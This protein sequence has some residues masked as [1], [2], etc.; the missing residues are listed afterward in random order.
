MQIFMKMLLRKTV[1]SVRPPRICLATSSLRASFTWCRDL[2]CSAGRNIVCHTAFPAR[3]PDNGYT[4]SL[5]APGCSDFCA[6]AAGM[7]GGGCGIHHQA[8]TGSFSLPNPY[9]QRTSC[10]TLQPK[11]SSLCGIPPF[12][13]ISI[14]P[15]HNSEAQVP[16]SRVS[17][18]R[19]QGLGIQ[20]LG[21]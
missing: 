3:W 7:Q 17:V 6:A 12:Q 10:K 2:V 21:V 15:I 16:G 8:A 19:L 18:F 20:D 5:P 9:K 1:A 11:K 4:S 14:W 13:G